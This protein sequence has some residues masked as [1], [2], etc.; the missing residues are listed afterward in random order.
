MN[1]EL[2]TMQKTSRLQF[3]ANMAALYGQTKQKIFGQNTVAL[4]G[5]RTMHL[6]NTS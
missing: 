5:I 2:E 3:E 1:N 4:V 6:S